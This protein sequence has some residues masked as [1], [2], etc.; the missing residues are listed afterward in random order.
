MALGSK[1]GVSSSL[2]VYSWVEPNLRTSSHVST[3]VCLR[4][5]ETRDTESDSLESLQGR[6]KKSTSRRY[7]KVPFQ[8]LLQARGHRADAHCCSQGSF[9]LCRPATLVRWQRRYLHRKQLPIAVPATFLIYRRIAPG[10]PPH[11]CDKCKDSSVE[12]SRKTSATSST[13]IW[14]RMSCS[15]SYSSTCPF[16]VRMR[17]S[18]LP[19]FSSQEF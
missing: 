1:I 19:L 18:I 12:P 17:S 4:W 15:T 10:H 7:Q 9:R 14:L 13:T 5:Y 3:H 16:G 8:S 11:S 6:D 2:L